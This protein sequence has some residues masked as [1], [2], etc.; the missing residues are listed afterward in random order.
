MALMN[1]KGAAAVLMDVRYRRDRAMARL[2]DFDPND[3]P[4]PPTEGDPADSPLFNRAVQGVYELGLDLQDL[5]HRAG[6]GTWPDQPRHDLIDTRGPLRWGRTITIS[7][8][9]ARADRHQDVIVKSSN[10]GTARVAMH[11]RRPIAAEFLA[12]L[13]LLEPTPVETSRR[14]H[15]R[16]SCRRAGRNC[17]P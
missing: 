8:I 16:R 1:A 12:K 3:R 17:R 6:D 15:A 5:H 4:R 14:P 2:P 11:D 13:G 7:A 10:I 9:T